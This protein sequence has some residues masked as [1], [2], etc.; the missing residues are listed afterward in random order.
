MPTPDC[1]EFLGNSLVS[2]MTRV[3]ERNYAGQYYVKAR[4]EAVRGKDA[5]DF[6]EFAELTPEYQ[7]LTD[8]IHVNAKG[9]RGVVVTALTGIYLDDSY[10]PLSNFYGC[11]PRA[12]FEEGIWHALQE[13]GIPCGKS[14]PLNVAKNSNQL[15]EDWAQGRRP[16]KAAMAAVEFLR[17]V[18]A[19]DIKRRAHLIDYFFYRLLAYSKNITDYKLADILGDDLSRQG[20]GAKIVDFTLKY[21]ES[22]MLPQYMAS[23]L[24]A[25]VFD[26][27]EIKV[28]GGEES[29][30]GTN[31]TSKKPADIWLE[32]K[33]R[34]TNLY[35]VTVKPVTRKRLDDVL[36]S[37][38]VTGHLS[39][40][41]TFVCR[42]EQDVKEL[43]VVDGYF[44]YKGKV[45]DF[46]DYRAFCLHLCVL[47]D[48]D[49]FLEV[50]SGLSALVQCKDVSMRT[51]LGWNE[52]FA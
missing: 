9:F 45:F 3:A 24:L 46:V 32:R 23:R 47:L 19:A 50:L 10:D 12:I 48:N 6:P 21:P 1:K 52:F 38:R 26:S 20:R 43:E 28:L 40:S 11:N 14:D 36:D 37:L 4:I 39:H 31:T 17:L 35:E 8:L 49:A 18:M 15:N 29:V 22:G 41:V 5:N 25:A 44:V 34:Q 7:L 30:F 42:M 51:K 27:S 2:S 16:Q 33:L 13:N